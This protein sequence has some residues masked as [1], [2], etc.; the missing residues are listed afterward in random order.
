MIRVPPATMKKPQ[1]RPL[2]PRRAPTQARSQSLV[3]DVLEAAIRV[4]RRDGARRFTTVR[5]AEEAGVSVGSLYQYFPNKEALLFRLQADEWQETWSLLDELLSE[6]D[7]PPLD[8]LRRVVVTFFHS[9]REEADLRVALDD[10]GALFRDAPEAKAH[11]AKARRR[12]QA[13][14]DEVIPT[15]SA[16]DRAFAADYVMNTMA[17]VAERITAQG[18]SRADVERWGRTTGETLCRFLLAVA[19]DP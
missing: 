5:V 12:M 16:A 18:R 15:A 13:F 8:R 7:V 6:P 4:L 1:K 9:E 2:S 11:V 17:A 14:V 19:R 10:A 3:D